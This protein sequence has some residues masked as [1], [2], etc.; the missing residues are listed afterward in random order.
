MAV[1][2]PRMGGAINLGQGF[3]DDGAPTGIALPTVS[4][5]GE[6]SIVIAAGTN[7]RVNA[8]EVEAGIRTAAVQWLGAQPPR[9]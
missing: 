1:N 8:H 2:R 9:D 4:P 5:D 6:N 7:G 3:P